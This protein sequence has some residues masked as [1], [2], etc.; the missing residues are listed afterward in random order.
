[1][2]LPQ[3]L[4]AVGGAVGV[5]VAVAGGFGAAVGL[6]SLPDPQGANITAEAYARAKERAFAASTL[7]ADE[8]GSTV[9]RIEVSRGAR[10]LYAG[11]RES[12]DDSPLAEEHQNTDVELGIFFHAELLRC[13]EFGCEPDQEW[14]ASVPLEWFQFD[15]AM[16]AASDPAVPAASFSGEV[17][18][19]QFDVVWHPEGLIVPFEAHRADS[20]SSSPDPSD[21]WRRRTHAFVS[22]VAEVSRVAPADILMDPGQAE[23][24]CLHYERSG[25]PGYLSRAAGLEPG[26]VMANIN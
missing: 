9:L 3:R 12:G 4:R 23:P 20:E 17:E 8:F 15:P 5:A 18:G 25:A 10:R 24:S 26:L 13:Y 21:P 1:M 11:V 6:Y 19:C 16:G 2:T 7:Q 14:D 22:G